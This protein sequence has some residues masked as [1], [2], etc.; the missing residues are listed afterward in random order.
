M[1]VTFLQD[2]ERDVRA[3]MDMFLPATVD[4]DARAREAGIP[5]P[6]VA[7]ARAAGSFDASLEVFRGFA[8]ERYHEDERILREAIRGYQLVWDEID[9]VFF[10]RV[11]SLTDLDWQFSEYKV[12]VSLFHRG[13]S[14]SNANTVIRWAYDQPREHARITAHEI[15]MIQL[16]HIFDRYFPE[17]EQDPH[18]HFWML[19]ELTATAVLGLDPVLDSL[20]ASSQKGYEGFLQNYPQMQQYKESIKTAYLQRDSFYQYLCSAAKTIRTHESAS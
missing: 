5:E 8:T 1:P 14:N 18:G 7:R 3:M 11:R 6:I 2:Q 19:N 17:A 9:Q 4:A 15:L 12:I 20:W 13:I 10:T 16:W